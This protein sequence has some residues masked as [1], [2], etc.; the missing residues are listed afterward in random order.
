M[1]LTNSGYDM[2]SF[3]IKLEDDELA[4]D[5][6]NRP[7]IEILADWSNEKAEMVRK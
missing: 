7:C 1:L 4:E 2:I 6:K 5:F 3:K